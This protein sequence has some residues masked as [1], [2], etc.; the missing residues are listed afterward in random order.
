MTTTPKPVTRT[1]QAPARPPRRTTACTQSWN[2]PR[3]SIPCGRLPCVCATTAI[4]MS[5]SVRSSSAHRCSSRPR[6]SV[7]IRSCGRAVIVGPDHGLV[8]SRRVA[9]AWPERVTADAHDRP[10][11]SHEAEP[12]RTPGSTGEG[13]RQR[14]SDLLRRGRWAGLDP[15]AVTCHGQWVAGSPSISP[16]K[17]PNSPTWVPSPRT[18]SATLPRPRRGSSCDDACSPMSWLASARW[19]VTTPRQL[20]SAGGVTPSAGGAAKSTAINP[21]DRPVDRTAVD[22]RTLE[23]PWRACT[24]GHKVSRRT[25]RPQA[26]PPRPKLLDRVVRRPNDWCPCSSTVARLGWLHA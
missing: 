11:E 21:A 14:S 19:A 15:S 24:E 26:F 3:C 25:G 9:R 12:A 6:R 16:R 22:P 8:R 2:A 10:S 4:T 13:E 7:A 17:A 20:A 5:S 1:P 18:S 23:P